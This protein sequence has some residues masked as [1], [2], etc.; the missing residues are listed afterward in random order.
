[1]EPV[2]QVGNTYELNEDIVSVIQILSAE[3]VLVRAVGENGLFQTAFIKDL[4]PIIVQA[5]DNNDELHE[6]ELEVMPVVEVV[7]VPSSDDAL[8]TITS[9]LNREKEL[10]SMNKRTVEQNAELKNARN[11]LKYLKEEHYDD[12]IENADDYGVDQSYIE[13]R[14]RMVFIGMP[15]MQAYLAQFKHLDLPTRFDAALMEVGLKPNLEK[16][17]RSLRKWKKFLVTWF[18]EKQEAPNAWDAALAIVVAKK[19]HNT[20]KFWEAFYKSLHDALPRTSAFPR[21]K[22]PPV[23]V[24]RVSLTKIY[25]VT[26]RL[27]S[28]PR[29][30]IRSAG[31][32]AMMA[33]AQGGIMFISDANPGN[34][35]DVMIPQR[36]RVNFTSPIV[37]SKMLSKT[38]YE[39]VTRSTVFSRSTRRQLGGVP[40]P[41]LTMFQDDE[42][43]DGGY[44]A[45]VQQ[46]LQY[47]KT[48][49]LSKPISET[50]SWIENDALYLI[51]LMLTTGNAKDTVDLL[52]LSGYQRNDPI[53]LTNAVLVHEAKDKKNKITD[54]YYM[55][56][57]DTAHPDFMVAFAFVRHVVGTTYTRLVGIY[58]YNV[59][60][61]V[62]EADFKRTKMLKNKI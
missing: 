43:P 6:E 28:K 58:L 15:R 9:A 41:V 29:S 14:R 54:V 39:N 49:F 62:D 34:I 48:T 52:P 42:N 17:N 16:T 35:L 10:E 38:F 22:T 27:G 50:H 21:M 61:K 26:V 23:D 1:M 37:F 25:D 56:T 11:Q 60:A 31:T 53:S 51:T 4:R 2:V 12:L 30:A 33:N 47:Y 7:M 45:G 19:P 24:P 55:K 44:S 57:F 59:G 3:Q 46:A 13:K 36:L 32:V 18:M 5:E 40:I 20:D 8:K